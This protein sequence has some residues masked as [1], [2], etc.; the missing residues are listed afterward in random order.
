V[1]VARS[2]PTLCDFMDC[3]CGILLARILEWVAILFFR[4]SSRPG[5]KP[6]SPTLQADSLPSEPSGKLNKSVMCIFMDCT[7]Y[8][9]TQLRI[10]QKVELFCSQ[11]VHLG[12][13]LCQ[14]YLLILYPER[15]LLS[16]SCMEAYLLLEALSLITFFF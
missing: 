4:G 14:T 8:K 6:A 1:L 2:C 15:I 7:L 10:E 13:G 11:V 12:A 3:V 16:G 5:V 9:R